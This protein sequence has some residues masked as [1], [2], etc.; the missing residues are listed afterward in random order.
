MATASSSVTG[1]TSTDTAGRAV[2]L[3]NINGQGPF[4]FVI[5]TG[6]N[7]SV[8][9]EALATRLG[10]AHSGEGVVHS[11]EGEELATLVNVESLS[12]GGLHLSGGDTPV[13]DG[14]MLD[15]EHGLLGVDGMAGRLLHVDFSKQCV[16]IYQSAAQMP[17]D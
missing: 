6:A 13:L 5:D 1:A 9:S 14:P 2:A 12:F 16:E 11:V 15:G 10:L 4:R 3:I 17:M 8:L 7:R